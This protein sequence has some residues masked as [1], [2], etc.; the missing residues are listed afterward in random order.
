MAITRGAIIAIV[1]LMFLVFIVIAVS[2]GYYY[3]NKKPKSTSPSPSPGKPAYAPFSSSYEKKVQEALASTATPADNPYLLAKTEFLTY[4]NNTDDRTKWAFQENSAASAIYFYKQKNPSDTGTNEY[5][6]IIGYETELNTLKTER[7]NTLATA[8]C[9]TGPY[10]ANPAG[11]N[12]PSQCR[13]LYGEPGGVI[14]DAGCKSDP[15]CKLVKDTFMA[16]KQC[17][18]CDNPKLTSGLYTIL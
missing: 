12:A 3:Y 11:P 6:E 7:N 18:P 10:P 16:T 15:K 1:G 5:K 17:M 4:K 9:P 8:Q 14:N 13:I 2:V